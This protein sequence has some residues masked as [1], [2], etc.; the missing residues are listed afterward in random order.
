MPTQ[1]SQRINFFH[2]AAPYIQQHR[3]RTFVIC[4][5]GEVLVH[6][7]YPALL[8]EIGILT[9]LGIKLVLVYGVRPQVDSQL[10]A[11]NHPIEIIN[12]LR[13]TDDIT[14][15]TAT[16]IIGQ[17]R[18]DIE[19]RLT[20]ILSVP[21]AIN[22]EIGILSGNLITAKPLGVIDGI[23]YQHTGEVRKVNTQLIRT[24]LDHNNLVLLPP[25]GFSPTGESFNL[26]FEEVASFAAK[27]IKADKLIFVQGNTLDLPKQMSKKE[28]LIALQSANKDPKQLYQNIMSALEHGVKR[29]HLLDCSIAD[30]LLLELFTRDGVGALFSANLYEDIRPALI[31]DVAGILALIKPLE[32]KGI[33]VRRSREQIELE[34]NNFTVIERDNTI[35]ACAAC[36]PHPKEKVAELACLAVHS[37]YLGEKRGDTLLNSIISQCENQ[38]L[39]RLIVLTTKTTNWFQERG[40]MIGT[41]KDLP[42]QKQQLYNFKRQS[43][44]LIKKLSI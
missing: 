20:Q 29:I 33:L 28:L 7:N 1:Y 3:D 38:Q 15:T 43:K 42:K 36:Y 5:S 24:L 30:T 16:Q 34:I 14:L 40:F 44:I 6:Q 27:A 8:K 26:R 4:L 22:N 23:D 17:I 31:D 2:E 35:I 13:I 21:P 41:I 18:I 12:D 25:L 37:S 39:E 10:K 19:N 11:I 9:T 32:K